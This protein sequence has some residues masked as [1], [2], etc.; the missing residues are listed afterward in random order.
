MNLTGRKWLEA[1][2]GCIMRSFITCTHHLTI[3]RMFK[4]RRMRWERQVARIGK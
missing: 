2:D 3:I 4:S 1:V